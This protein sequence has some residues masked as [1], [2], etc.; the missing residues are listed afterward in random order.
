VIM[1]L[2][3]SKRKS[4]SQEDHWIP[5]SDIMTGLMMVFMLVAIVFMIQ[6]KREE[7][8]IEQQATAIKNLTLDYSDIRTQLYQDLLAT[9]K[10]DL[11]KWQAEFSPKTLSLRFK[12][13]S[14]QFD[15]E[16]CDIKD[17]FAGILRSFFPRYISVL[18][19]PKY[20]NEIEEIRVEGHTSSKW[21][22][23]SREDAYFRNMELSQ[24]RSR[25][26]AK[27]V[28]KVPEI[29]GVDQLDKL[30]FAIRLLTA[31]GLSSS[32]SIQFVDKAEDEKSSQRVEFRVRTT[33]EA[34]LEEILKALPR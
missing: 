5:L 26:V 9:F 25:E 6:I 20:R 31:N 10:E 21:G 32:K 15:S 30:A 18:Y 1:A 3:A 17:G 19:S 27:Y 12:E 7:A 22:A 28:L 16:K 2:E 8:K 23:L 33:A 11:P 13:P 4:H 24:C 29:R 14:V 34:R